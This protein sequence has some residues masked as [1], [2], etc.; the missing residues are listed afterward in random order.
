[1]TP[2]CTENRRLSSL[3]QFLGTAQIGGIAE[4]LRPSAGESASFAL[5]ILTRLECRHTVR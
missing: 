2:L 4:R 1:M 3:A 5:A